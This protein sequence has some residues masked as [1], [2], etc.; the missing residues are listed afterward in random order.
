MIRRT[1]LALVLT[2]AGAVSMRAQLAPNADWRVLR[3]PHFRV[4]FT[5]A[6]ESQARRAAVNAE[7]AYGQ[8]AGELTPPRGTIDL[9]ISDDVDFTNGYA[10]T[11]PTNRIVIYAN[12]PVNDV[13]LRFTDDADAMVVTHELT[14]IFHLDRS[15]GI[16]DLAQHVFGRAPYL[17][18]NAYAPRW[19]TE[20]LAV[21]Y[22]S[23]FTGAGRVTGSDHRMIAR[24]LAAEQ[25]FPSIDE[26]SLADA[27]FPYGNAAYVFGSL[28][29][30]Y[31]AQTR[32]ERSLH[33]FVEDEASQLIPI[34]LNRPAG[35][36]FGISFTT[37]WKRW[38][39]SVTRSM[40]EPGPPTP[41]WRYLTAGG[42]YA[43]FPRWADDTAIT[44]TG[45]DGR[46]SY[47]AY[48]VA[49]DGTVE[50]LERRNSDSPTLVLPDGEQLFTQL[51]FVDAYHV[52]SDLFAQRGRRTVRL[53]HGARLTVPDVTADGR[54]VAVQTLP[55]ATQLV[56]LQSDG[57]GLRVLARG[58]EDVQWTEPRWS[59]DGQYIAAARWQRGGT[60]E[61]VVLDTTGAIVQRIAPAHAV[62]AAPS[63]S[64]DGTRIFFSSDR[65]GIT[66]IYSARFA[67]AG[68]GGAGG[69]DLEM[70]TNVATGMFYPSV[71]P[72]GRWLAAS[73]VLG[74]GYHVGVGALGRITPVPAAPLDS[75]A[76]PQPAPPVDSVTTPMTRFSPW[77]GLWPRYWMPVEEA[78]IAGGARVGAYTSGV[79][80]V[81]RHSYSAQLFVPTDRTGLTG[82]FNY[83]YAGLGMPVL[84]MN[85]EQ[86]WENNGVIRDDQRNVVGTLRKRTRIVT[87]GATYIRPRY[88]TY[89]SLSL[90]A[91]LEAHDYA[92]DPAP[93]LA[94]IDSSYARA[95]YYPTLIASGVWSNAQRPTLSISP[96]DGLTGAAT[97][98]ERF[99]SGNATGATFSAVASA[100][101]Y[102]SINLPT[103]A[104]Q[105]LA[106]T[107]AV[108]YSDDR[109]TSYF[110]VG[111][112]SGSTITIVP[113][114]VL[115]QGRRTFPVRG[116]DAASLI[117]LRAFAASAEYRVPLALLDR[118]WGMLPFFLDRSSLSAFY[119][120]GGAW[121]PA[122]LAQGP[123]CHDPVLAQHFTIAS[124]GAEFSLTAA[125]L[126]W[127]TPYQFRFGVAL[128]THNGA[129]V[130][131]RSVSTYFSL[132]LS[133]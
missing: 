1:L 69:N 13:A 110:E 67:P 53:T 90:L 83:A 132:G 81:G 114:V 117:G 40:G 91:G 128:P 109:S 104:H 2:A 62:Q 96:E 74:D 18:P 37:A 6:L 39:D 22:E 72:D 15:R 16:W 101:A 31:L 30:N 115:G 12:P 25:R 97:V 133:F 56:L 100:S 126:D 61:I 122:V 127:D 112:A 94:R 3:T 70:L 9:V 27:R 49:L 20:G 76:L 85:G 105:V 26:I 106:V 120:A 4:L 89:S 19:L 108:G 116:F 78:S 14:H 60:S 99:T 73:V 124:A 111:G 10:T 45:S 77:S 51:E 103:F 93:L 79:D 33:N 125:V 46:A 43:T 29:V 17:F 23:R 55:A 57:T 47:G 118:G 7:V 95:Y 88:R 48:S 41:G 11:F 34:W 68:T 92:T 24:A 130:G 123:V 38:D 86:D 87:L 71:S 107:G 64:P 21:Y 129:L 75:Q 66:N 28:F 42:G 119:D 80:V 102:K 58:N 8:L 36:A 113:G 50:R 32:G 59:P 131:A 35:E 44:F 84:S 5:P 65:T 82:F 98:R 63:W 52:R 121:C 54:I